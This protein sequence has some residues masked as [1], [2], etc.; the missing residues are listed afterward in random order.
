MFVYIVSIYRKFPTG[1]NYCGI[2]NSRS[3][4]FRSTSHLIFRN[5]LISNNEPDDAFENNHK[6]LEIVPAGRAPP[7]ADHS[8]RLR[9]QFQHRICKRFVKF[10]VLFWIVKF[11]VQWKNEVHPQGFHIRRRWGE[12][13]QYFIY[14]TIPYLK[15]GSEK[16]RTCN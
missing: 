7:R 8:V 16:S 2:A 10:Q 4:W 14:Y 13:R 9:L 1:K 5:F 12:F 6:L 3:D 11:V 15:A